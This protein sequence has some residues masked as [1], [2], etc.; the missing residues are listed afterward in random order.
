MSRAGHGPVDGTP[1]AGGLG[2]E[3]VDDIEL[4]GIGRRLPGP[5]V[6]EAVAALASHRL[7]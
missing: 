5:L 4:E 7:R 3:F 1:T 2:D 6:H